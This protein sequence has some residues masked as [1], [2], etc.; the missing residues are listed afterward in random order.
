M[1]QIPKA[2]P[3]GSVPLN[4]NRLRAESESARHDEPGVNCE[5]LLTAI[6]RMRRIT[7]E[8][9]PYIHDWQCNI[10]GVAWE[11]ALHCGR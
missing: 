10:A 2:A 6:P 8:V 1:H 11:G 5:D 3:G 7:D 4:G 9:E